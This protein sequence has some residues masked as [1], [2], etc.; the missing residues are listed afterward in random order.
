MVMQAH[1]LDQQRRQGFQVVHFLRRE[2]PVLAAAV[3]VHRQPAV[4]FTVGQQGYP[5]GNLWL[6]IADAP[7]LGVRDV[8]S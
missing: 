7:V 3:E 4:A 5:L 6:L 1:G 8:V 2:A